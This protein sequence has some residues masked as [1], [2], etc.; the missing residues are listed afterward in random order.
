MLRKHS[1]SKL[2]KALKTSKSKQKNKAMLSR[3][4]GS[5]RQRISKLKRIKNKVVWKI[6]TLKHNPNKIKCFE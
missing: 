6:Q 1:S 5:K 3:P 4:T 2:K